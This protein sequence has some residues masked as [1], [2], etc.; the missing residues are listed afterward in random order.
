LF[1][2]IERQD[3]EDGKGSLGNAYSA[4]CDNRRDVESVWT[5]WKR[6]SR[7]WHT[8]RRAADSRDIAGGL[9]AIEKHS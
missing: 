2:E 6:R 9:F 8:D 3:I 4:S 1:T 5:R 7:A